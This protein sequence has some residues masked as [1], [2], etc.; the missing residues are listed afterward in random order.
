MKY[1]L[2]DYFSGRTSLGNSERA[3]TIANLIP[4]F[5]V[6]FFGWS[7]F[8]IMFLY[9]FENVIIGILNLFKMYRAEMIA[10]P[11]ALSKNETYTDQQTSISRLGFMIFFCCH[12]G[13]FMGA[14]GAF[15]FIIFGPSDFGLLDFAAGAIPLLISH[16]ISYH[17]NYIGHE[18][19]RK[20]PVTTLFVSPYARMTA[21]HISMLA[22]G[23]MV[24]TLDTPIF[25]LAFLVVF[26]IAM[27]ISAH[28][29]EHLKHV[30]PA[31]QSTPSQIS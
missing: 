29:N 11:N 3:L 4:L 17:T 24:Q 22:G 25:A 26:K 12:Y 2:K 20:I 31:Q 8:G 10:D 27:D 21:L 9:W 19:Y 7:L 23:F 14:H 30:F 18:E 15:V 5:G 13:L 28:Q 1:R 16:I 6:M